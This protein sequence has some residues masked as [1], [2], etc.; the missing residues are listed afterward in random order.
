MTASA[1]R[2]DEEKE[3]EK[4]EACYTR[5]RTEYKKW[6]QKFSVGNLTGRYHEENSE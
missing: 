2:C 3:D 6:V 5:S 1:L 4:D